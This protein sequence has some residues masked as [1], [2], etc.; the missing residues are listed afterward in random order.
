MIAKQRGEEDKAHHFSIIKE[1]DVLRAVTVTQAFAK[2]IG[3]DA[4]ML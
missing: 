2:T 1:A 4:V 3:F